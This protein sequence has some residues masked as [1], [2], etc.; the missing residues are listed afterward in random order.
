[1]IWS[2]VLSA[3]EVALLATFKPYGAQ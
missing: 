1:M 2:R 3:Q